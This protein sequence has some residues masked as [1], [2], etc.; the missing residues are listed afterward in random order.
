MNFDIRSIPSSTVLPF[1][2]KYMEA[3][4]LEDYKLLN[5][6][7]EKY[8]ESYITES[9]ALTFIN[10][11]RMSEAEKIRIISESVVNVDDSFYESITPQIDFLSGGAI[12]PM[13]EIIH[14][15]ESTSVYKEYRNERNW[16]VNTIVGRQAS[17]VADE[18]DKN[19]KSY[20]ESSG[21]NGFDDETR[22]IYKT[23][24]DTI[25][26]SGEVYESLIN[27]KLVTGVLSPTSAIILRNF[28]ENSF[29]EFSVA[30][31]CPED[32]IYDELPISKDLPLED[33]AV[34]TSATT[35]DMVA[36]VDAEISTDEKDCFTRL[37]YDEDIE[38]EGSSMESVRYLLDDIVRF[39]GIN[40][41]LEG[42]V[43]KNNPAFD[44]E[45]KKLYGKLREYLK[46]SNPTDNDASIA[47]CINEE[48][49]RYLF[50]FKDDINTTSE[51]ISSIIT[52]LSFKPIKNNG[53][54]LYY[55]KVGKGIQIKINFGSISGG[56]AISY[57]NNTPVKES[58]IDE[59][60]KFAD[61]CESSDVKDAAKKVK[62]AMDS[63]DDDSK[64]RLKEAINNLDHAIE[65]YKD[66]IKEQK[67]EIKK[68][69]KDVNESVG[70]DKL[71][72]FLME[73]TDINLFEDIAKAVS[74]AVDGS[75]LYITD[76]MY[77][78][79]TLCD[80][81]KDSPSRQV[82]ESTTAMIEAAY[83]SNSRDEFLTKLSLFKNSLKNQVEDEYACEAVLD[84]IDFMVES[85][86]ADPS[87]IDS[88]IK[89]TVELLNRLGYKVKYSCSGHTKTRI[90]ED[91]FNDGVYHGKLYTTARLIFD[92][93]YRFSSIPKGWYQ[94]KNA[95]TTSI[96][97][98]AFNYS[99]KDGT[100]NE[101][102]EKWKQEYMSSLKE[103]AE[104][105]KEANESDE[106]AKM[107]SIISSLESE[108]E[109]IG[110][111]SEVMMENTMDEDASITGD[112]FDET[113][114][115]LEDEL[116]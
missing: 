32:S 60:L 33:A 8:E 14:V 51:Q 99:K 101:A 84:D 95:G 97:V 26:T 42:T 88:D 6:I 77:T 39:N 17:I 41:L 31:M 82:F 1:N 15:N 49:N 54:I 13:R 71:Y 100:P 61:E 30:N 105:L 109:F 37:K 102:F 55:E 45:V 68:V 28:L 10:M 19:L 5:L 3:K 35:E 69:I 115:Q 2:S 90:K 50:N 47:E 108:F 91:G 16:D 11:V 24:P 67:Y 106:D 92:K 103:W 114:K 25:P 70:I 111:S 86:Q 52:G 22:K 29:N 7:T 43:Y 80:I 34:S 104:N 27:T 9:E 46:V 76:Y 96:Y 66:V 23:F 40:L 116:F 113:L 75:T 64:E 74:E 79:Y 36:S 93:N 98:R 58:A 78:P 63:K 72:V 65:N 12:L 62:K 83:S 94:N 18:K 20:I 48:K 4:V 81:L 107:E 112:V 56:I 59:K 57:E 87:E 38:N 53:K 73:N 89:S 44:S 85:K 21:K 110:N